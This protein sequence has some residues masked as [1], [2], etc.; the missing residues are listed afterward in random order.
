MKR[1]I[2]ILLLVIFCLSCFVSCGKSGDAGRRFDF[3]LEVEKSRYSR[4]ETINVTAE[5]TNVSGWTY[6]YVG[7]SGNDF[8]PAIS[9]YFDGSADGQSYYIPC[10]PIVLPTDVVNKKVKNGESGSN[11]YTFKIPEDA[12]LG[13][14]SVT[15]SMGKDDQAFFGVLEIVELTSQN[16]TEKYSYSSAIVSSGNANI[17]P[18]KT[19]SYQGPGDGLGCEGIF[20]D[21]E[22][23]QSDFPT[24]V[25]DRRVTVTHSKNSE[26][27]NPRVY[28][29]NYEPIKYLG[30]GWEGVHLL[31][32]GEYIVVFY[33]M[34]DVSDV[35]G[36]DEKYNVV[37]YEDVFKLI[38]PRTQNLSG[39][40]F[41][42]GEQRIYPGSQMLYTK[43][44]DERIGDYVRNEGEGASEILAAIR[45]SEVADACLP[46]L[47]IEGEVSVRVPFNGM[48]T[49][50]KLITV[51]DS[52][53]G[54]DKWNERVVTTEELSK[55]PKGKYYIVATVLLSGNC[56][57]YAPQNV[58]CYEDVFKLIVW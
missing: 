55:L 35:Y 3:S 34:I 53:E 44:Y 26:I 14:Y 20:S 1:T 5:V 16:E 49:D 56:D 11:V 52:E 57:P 42:S 9:L 23:D 13:S 12:P 30:P 4:G 41:A 58:Y 28:D 6:R 51:G 22:T 18:I 7:C 50:V 32:V 38:V 37:G 36:D 2:V 10:D 15:L 33:E 43:I 47:A 21:P 40:S 27:G 39:A 31:P 48:V 17:R 45:N 54:E 46:T 29:L 19:F 24:L 8:I 25:A